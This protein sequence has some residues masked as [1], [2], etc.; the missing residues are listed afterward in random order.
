ME[1]G[2]EA[3][4]LPAGARIALA[5]E[6]DGS[7]YFGWQSQ[8]KPQVAT[9]QECLET[10]LSRVADAPLRVQC[11]GRT[12]RGVHASHQV[13]HFDSPAAR[14]PRAWVFGGNS[15]LPESIA[16]KWA[17]GVPRNF[18]ARFSAYARRYRYVIC[19][20]ALRSPHLRHAVTWHDRPL[21]ARL[22]HE[23]AQALIGEL[24]FSAFRAAGCQSN[25]PMRNVHF[26]E[27]TRRGDFVVIDIQANAFLHHMVRNVAGVLMAVGAGEAA[28][29]WTR[30][31]LEGR[32]R[33]AGGITAPPDGLYLVDVRYPDEFELPAVEPG[34]IF[35]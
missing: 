30:A 33:T 14:S 32:D 17:R 29:G 11:A 20:R 34:P 1:A 35:L 25:S 3:V 12:D 6:Y 10:A 31:V 5:L 18:H 9:V 13:V 22:M 23:D 21:D 4:V 2:A 26:V 7:A 27:V 15:H 24:D 8:R 19:N 16:V 28:P